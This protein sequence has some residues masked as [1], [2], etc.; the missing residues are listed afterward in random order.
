ML[1]LLV[2]IVSGSSCKKYLTE[3]PSSQFTA[4]FVY[5]T[6]EGLEAGVVS[7]YNFQRNFWENVGTNNGSD[8][9]VI[10]SRDDLTIPRGGE[11]SNYGRMNNGTR[12]DN[13]GVFGTYWKTYYRL[14]D[15]ANGIIKAAES[16]TG[17]DEERRKKVLGEAKFFRAN[18]VFIL[19][20]LFNNIFV[21]TEPTTPANALDIVLDKTPE[22]DHLPVNQ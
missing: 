1:V 16:I 9:I 14:I 4:E 3:E 7:L 20:K 12:P 10:D 15:R 17:M 11:I 22:A 8:P 5:N 13:S 6:P 21:T 2:L 18:S 19:Y